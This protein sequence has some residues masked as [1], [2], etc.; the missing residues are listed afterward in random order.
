[1]L[2]LSGNSVLFQRFPRCEVEMGTKVQD[3]ARHHRHKEK[4]AHSGDN[5]ADC[6]QRVQ[7]NQLPGEENQQAATKGNPSY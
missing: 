1:M 7:S 3:N 2:M 4:D 6:V 5:E